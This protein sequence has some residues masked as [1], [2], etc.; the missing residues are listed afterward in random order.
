MKKSKLVIDYEFNF[1]SAGDHLN[2][3]RLQARLGRQ[4]GAPYIIGE[5][6]GFA[7]RI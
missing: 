7:R 2:S 1:E 6:T 3:Q 5:T 4:P